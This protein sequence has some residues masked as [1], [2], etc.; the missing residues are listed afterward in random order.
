MFLW[1]QP[2]Q[3]SLLVHSQLAWAIVVSAPCGS[4]DPAQIPSGSL[5]EDMSD[6]SFKQLA[7][8]IRNWW[9]AH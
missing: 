7:S 9:Q 3:R 4:R 8:K 2:S 1:R 6:D 5:W